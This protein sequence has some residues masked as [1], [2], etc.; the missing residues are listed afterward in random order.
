MQIITFKFIH[1]LSLKRDG[2]IG[3]HSCIQY[4]SKIHTIPT[5]KT[6][7][8]KFFNNTDIMQATFAI[9]FV[10]LN[11]QDFTEGICSTASE[12][13]IVPTESFFKILR[14]L[15]YIVKFKFARSDK[16]NHVGG[17]VINVD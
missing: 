16:V 12:S 9:T 1:I 13:R 17:M 10:K 2:K 8:F 14:S 7:F 3:L 4:F 11:I 15:S 6:F 5:R